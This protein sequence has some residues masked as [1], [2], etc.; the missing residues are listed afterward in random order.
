MEPWYWLNENSRTFL[1]RGYLIEGQTPEGRAKEIGETAAKILGK[2]EFADKFVDYMS[3][4]WISL[5]TPVWTNFGLERGLPISCFG[6]YVPDDMANILHSQAEVGMMSKYGGGTSGYFGAL[7]GRGADVVE[8]R[9]HQKL[10]SMRRGEHVPGRPRD[11]LPS[12]THE[13]HATCPAL[14]VP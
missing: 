14:C 4:G 10:L 8:H 12:D 9:R 2:P 6:S 1:S 3:K 11:E 5:A 7:R 13:L